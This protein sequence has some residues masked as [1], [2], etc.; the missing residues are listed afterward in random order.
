MSVEEDEQFDEITKEG[1]AKEYDPEY[2]KELL[3][4]VK[5]HFSQVTWNEFHRKARAKAGGKAAGRARTAASAAAQ[6][7][8]ATTAQAVTQPPEVEAQL[9]E[10]GRASCRERVSSPV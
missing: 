5:P 8:E 2:V 1:T 7:S 3:A 6:S 10:I 4:A 9:Q